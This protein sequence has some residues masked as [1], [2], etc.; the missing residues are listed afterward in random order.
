[1]E[2][3]NK[4]LG[5]GQQ[6]IDLAR[7]GVDTV[8]GIINP[9]TATTPLASVVPAT[10]TTAGATAGVGVNWGLIVGAILAAVVLLFVVFQRR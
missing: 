4:W 10:A 5:V 2:W 7:T 3:L 6:A 9:A 1:M 8:G